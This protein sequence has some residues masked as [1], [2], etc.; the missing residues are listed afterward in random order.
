ME[1]ANY[2]IKLETSLT[3]ITTSKMQRLSRCNHILTMYHDQ[4][5]IMTQYSCM[6]TFMVYIRS[7]RES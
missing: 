4:D 1:L 7:V 3:I 2:I 5:S 6:F